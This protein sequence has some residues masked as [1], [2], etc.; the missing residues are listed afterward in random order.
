M[1]NLAIACM[2]LVWMLA[3]CQFQNHVHNGNENTSKGT[4]MQSQPGDPAYVTLHH[5]GV[6]KERGEALWQRMDSCDLCPRNCSARR[7]QGER[8]VCKANS[9]LEIG[10]HG[11]HFG[12]EMELV[13]NSGSGTIFFTN[14]ALLCVFCINADISQQGVGRSYTVN[15][16][17]EMMLSLQRRGCSNI[18][19]VSPS[20]Y[21]P[22]I[23]LALD[24]AAGKGLRLPIV[25]NTCGWEKGDVLLYLDSV[26][27]IYLTDFK[28]GCNAEAAKYSPGAGDYVE[29]TREAHL[30]MQ[31][32]VGTLHT[33]SATGLA[34]RGLMIRHLVMPNNVTCTK[35]IMQWIGENLPKDTYINIMS[36]YTPV[37]NANEHPVINRR[38]TQQEYRQAVQAAEDAGLTNLK[39]QGGR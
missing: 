8:G 14:C 15:Q 1:R 19:L 38:I 10:S 35:E 36:Q 18:N 3:S 5:Q 29:V 32:Q 33:D 6:L 17:A 37:F 4:D 11:P 9:T 25:Y 39:L 28:Y 23:L 21:A 24:I 27:D 7:L 34:T 13:G 22:H 20:H 16:L 30:I 12:E 31:E 2:A 26:V